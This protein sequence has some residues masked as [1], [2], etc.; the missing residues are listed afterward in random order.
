MNYFNL[1]P[2]NTKC[3]NLPIVIDINNIVFIPDD[4][5][6]TILETLNCNYLYLIT[7]NFSSGLPLTKNGIPFIPI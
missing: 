6:Y 4:L 5:E 7:I 1:F 2:N 3:I